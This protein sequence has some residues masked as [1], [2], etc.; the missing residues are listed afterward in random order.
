APAAG[1]ASP[2][3][4]SLPPDTAM[5][6]PPTAPAPPR[7]P[8]SPAPLEIPARVV[9]VPGLEPVRMTCTDLSRAGTFVC[10]EG[11]LPPL[12]SRVALTLELRDRHLL[13]TGEVVR[14]VTPAQASLWGMR[15]GFAVQF[16]DLPTEARD[17]LS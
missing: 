13:C 15:A 10:T 2:P 11:A 9:L 7:R 5:G 14:H 17:A 4:P 12:R 1:M 6:I 8:A 3:P 16:T